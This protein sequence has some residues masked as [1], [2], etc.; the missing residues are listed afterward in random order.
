MKLVVFSRFFMFFNRFQ[1]LLMFIV[2]SPFSLNRV[3]IGILCVENCSGAKTKN[4]KYTEH[5]RGAEAS[6]A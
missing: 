1:V 5:Y 3:L 2:L 6:N 4:G